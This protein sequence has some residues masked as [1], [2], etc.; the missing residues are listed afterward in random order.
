MG[1]NWFG[2]KTIEKRQNISAY[3]KMRASRRNI[4]Y[5]GCI[6]NVAFVQSQI[7]AHI[8]IT[9]PI[10]YSFRSDDADVW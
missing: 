5:V 10:T 7:F 1:K 6:G 9:A 3:K 2:R 8:S 4:S